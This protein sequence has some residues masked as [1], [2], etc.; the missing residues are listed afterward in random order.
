MARRLIKPDNPHVPYRAQPRR[1]R[2]SRI[3]P[4]GGGQLRRLALLRLR[5]HPK[6]RSGVGFLP[7]LA[8]LSAL[9]VVGSVVGGVAAAGGAR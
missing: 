4:R 1:L 6:R 9:L 2:S 8:T 7:M 3:V 5:A